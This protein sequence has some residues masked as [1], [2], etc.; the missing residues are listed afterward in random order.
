MTT[1]PRTGRRR[2]RPTERR[3][4]CTDRPPGRAVT[5]TLIVRGAGSA[6]VEV[7]RTGTFP[8]LWAAGD[9]RWHGCHSCPR[10]ASVKIK[11]RGH[12]RQQHNLRWPPLLIMVR[13]DLLQRR[14]D[15]QD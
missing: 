3:L 8:V 1:S 6:F 4:S 14:D 11:D 10:F 9:E 15:D 7:I 2:N 12:L 13:P 5:G